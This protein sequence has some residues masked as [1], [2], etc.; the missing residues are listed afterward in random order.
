MVM[1]RQIALETQMALLEHNVPSNLR[2]FIANNV[3]SLVGTNNDL[4]EVIVGESRRLVHKQVLTY[5][6]LYFETAISSR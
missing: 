4:I 1:E 6:S 5:W 2:D 3:K